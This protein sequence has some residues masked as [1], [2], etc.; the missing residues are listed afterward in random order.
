RPEADVQIPDSRPAEAAGSPSAAAM[1][2]LSRATSSGVTEPETCLVPTFLAVDAYWT[3][4]EV[5]HPQPTAP[6]DALRCYPYVPEDRRVDWRENSK[7]VV[8][9][10]NTLNKR[11]GADYGALD[12]AELIVWPAELV[13]DAERYLARSGQVT[14]VKQDR[15]EVTTAEGK[16]AV[17]SLEIGG[18]ETV[19]PAVIKSAPGR[20]DEIGFVQCAA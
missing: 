14:S 16:I 11:Y 2:R 4:D 15:D 12:C 9:L 19:D 6:E 1:Q 20:L 7:S 10:S 8:G 13:D 18:G 5:F 3:H 17:K